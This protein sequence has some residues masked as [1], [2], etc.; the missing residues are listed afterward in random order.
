MCLMSETQSMKPRGEKIHSMCVWL[1]KQAQSEQISL[2]LGARN[3]DA[4]RMTVA[5]CGGDEKI[6]SSY[7]R[8]GSKYPNT[9]LVSQTARKKEIDI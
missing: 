1:F 8:G 7:Q 3:R 4:T 2:R 9:N 6:S 5:Q